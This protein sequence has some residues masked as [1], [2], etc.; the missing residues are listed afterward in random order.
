MG[1]LT[2]ERGGSEGVD[3]DDRKIPRLGTGGM[4]ALITRNKSIE[5]CTDS[6]EDKSRPLVV[7]KKNQLL[8]FY[9]SRLFIYLSALLLCLG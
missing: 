4:P 1:G 6:R 9:L 7:A 2:G 8:F 5:E 3:C